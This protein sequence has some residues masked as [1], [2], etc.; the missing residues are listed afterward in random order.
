MMNHE[1]MIDLTD[2]MDDLTNDVAEGAVM[3]DSGYNTI[4]V[5]MAISGLIFLSNAVSDFD[6]MGRYDLDGLSWILAL[7]ADRLKGKPSPEEEAGAP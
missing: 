5:E 3:T 7:I 4:D 6:T 1:E 2:G